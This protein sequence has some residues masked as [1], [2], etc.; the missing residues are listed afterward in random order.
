MDLVRNQ[1]LKQKIP[2]SICHKLDY[3]ICLGQFG[4]MRATR[5]PSKSFREKKKKATRAFTAGSLYLET[6]LFSLF[7]LGDPL[8]APSKT[9]NMNWNISRC[10][11]AD[12]PR[13]RCC[14]L[15]KSDQLSTS[16]MKMVDKAGICSSA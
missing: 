5:R 3:N 9:P 2:Q 11:A 16:E 13:F 10:R 1:S 15:R 7:N 14:C 8:W 6:N 4:A 12:F